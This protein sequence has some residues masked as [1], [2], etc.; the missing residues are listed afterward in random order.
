[1]KVQGN[2]RRTNVI[3]SMNGEAHT[4][5]EWCDIVNLPYKTVIARINDRGWT[6]EQAI[7]TPIRAHN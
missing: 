7:T 6:F 5:S 2:N 1:M 4:L 3:Y